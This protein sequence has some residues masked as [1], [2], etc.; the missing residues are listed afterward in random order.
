VKDLENVDDSEDLIFLPSADEN[1]ENSNDEFM[2]EEEF[3]ALLKKRGADFLQSQS[4]TYS[5]NIETPKEDTAVYEEIDKILNN[6]DPAKIDENQ[7][8]ETGNDVLA[9]QDIL[10]DSI[11]VVD[12]SNSAELPD[13]QETNDTE[14]TQRY[15][16]QEDVEISTTVDVETSERQATQEEQF[17]E[18][19]FLSEENSV[20]VEPKENDLVEEPMEVQEEEPAKVSEDPVDPVMDPVEPEIDQVEPEIDQVE[21]SVEN[22]PESPAEKQTDPPEISEPQKT[23]ENQEI[24]LED[25]DIPGF[26]QLIAD[27]D[28]NCSESDSEKTVM[29]DYEDRALAFVE[30]AD[31]PI[32]KEVTEEQEP[33]KEN[34]E[35]NSM[36]SQVE[37]GLS[38]K[39]DE[40][41]E[42]SLESPAYEELSAET[43][44]KSD[45]EMKDQETEQQESI[46]EPESQENP[47]EL[48]EGKQ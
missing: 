35:G 6:T 45:V 34:D 7:N 43:E 16:Y 12:D 2:D 19:R 20:E 17:E 23:P 33:E 29:F 46:V 18:L 3:S 8:K 48:E 44:E 27:I 42:N 5:D 24:Q 1:S 36:Q 30:T 11:C 32:K 28:A 22:P 47:K 38:E 9:T 21:E 25:F 13:T 10:F 15:D 26:T 41:G 40:E 14:A 39:E 37:N 31:K 4:Q